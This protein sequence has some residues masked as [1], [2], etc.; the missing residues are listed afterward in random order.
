MTEIDPT[1]EPIYKVQPL[2]FDA[3]RSS[4]SSQQVD[5]DPME[6]GTP[7]SAITP[8]ESLEQLSKWSEISGTRSACIDAIAL[9]T[10]GLGYMV[11]VAEGHEEDVQD[12]RT[13]AREMKRRLEGLAARDRRLEGP[14]LTELLKI[15]KKDEEETGQGYLE[16]SRRRTNGE[17]DGLYH[18]PA[19][20][21]RRLK[22]REGYMLL[23]PSG[24]EDEATFYYNFGDKADYD[25]DGKA[26]SIRS[27]REAT[28]NELITFKLY[29]SESRDYGLPRDSALSL[30]YLG[31]KLAAQSNV[32]FFDSSG[33]PPTVLFIQGEESSGGAEGGRRVINVKVPEETGQRIAST[34]RSDGKSTSRVAIV[35]IPTGAKV[36][37]EALGTISERD[38][39]FVAYRDDNRQRVLSAFRM[40]PIFVGLAEDSRYGAEIERE[41]TLEQVFDPEQ[42]RYEQRLHLTVFVDLGKP[43]L[44]MDFN[45]LAVAS[46]SQRRDSAEKLAEAGNIT[47]RQH[48]AAH[49]YPPMPE[50]A[51]A[52]DELEWE[53]RVYKSE[54]PAPGQVPAGWNDEMVKKDAGGGPVEGE[55]QQGL[56]PGIG[57]RSSR[58]DGQAASAVERTEGNVRRLSQR[59]GNATRGGARRALDRARTLP[60]DD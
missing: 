30:E 54:E 19:K 18:A 52:E 23:T 46:N 9:N 6:F 28:R 53:G 2:V 7:E 27:D 55:G 35:P 12:P 14:S 26:V 22:S 21:V 43:H 38:M 56:R 37:K 20:R 24:D 59:S 25:D 29:T 60:D 15:V 36:Q 57:G 3:D 49:G 45:R 16:V 11:V 5:E 44:I 39:G 31:D 58:D 42:T 41:I 48:L 32:G 8:P 4:G 13:E 10:V 33:T 34:L 47:R 17:I 50:A 1:A 40:S 51:E